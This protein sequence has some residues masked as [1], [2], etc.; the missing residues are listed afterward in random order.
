MSTSPWQALDARA[1]IAIGQSKGDL[2]T[3]AAPIVIASGFLLLLIATFGSVV[4]GIYM[5]SDAVSLPLIG[6]LYPS[7]PN[8]AD[9]VVG[10]GGWYTGLW[11]ELVTRF[12]PFHWQLWEVGPWFVSLAAVGLVVW[13]VVRVAGRWAGALVAFILVCAGP[14][15]LALQFEWAKHGA[16]VVNICVLGASLVLLVGRDG[17]IGGWATHLAASAVVVAITAAG[18]AS[19]ELLIPT[20]V[21]PFMLAGVLLAYILPRSVGRRIGLTVAGVGAL[22][23]I[24]SRV[25]IAAMAAHHIHPVYL[26]I[27]FAMWDRIG[28]NAVG[29]AESLAALFNGDFSG[30]AIDGRSI[31]ALACAVSLAAGIVVVVRMGGEW[32]RDLARRIA[33]GNRDTSH[34]FGV[35]AAYVTFWLL[36]GTFTSAAF[37]LSSVAGDHGSRYLLPLAYACTALVALAVAD[38]G[39]WYR[40]AVLLGASVIAAGSVV[41]LAARD[42][43]PDP[44]AKSFASVL[45]AFAQGEGLTYGY[46]HYWDS[47]QLAGVLHGKLPI[48]PIEPCNASHG[49]CRFPFNDISS[50]YEPRPATRTFVIVDPRY[51]VDPGKRLGGTDAALTY[52]YYTVLVYNYDIASNLGPAPAWLGT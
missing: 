36:V 46:A 41:S 42:L 38:R 50:W 16:S 12:L 18:T 13:S 21:I 20:G 39:V 40:R 28:P 3:W 24:G 23:L 25:V 52:G 2:I 43:R 29:L 11:F 48:Y 35:R 37:V 31:L 44:G 34:S 27:R 5:D 14:T 1:R 4:R 10:F 7:A 49:L 15:L 6:E 8:H 32:S 22:S 45:L 30:A 9:V 17:K 51:G 33:I 26:P 47:A 19:D